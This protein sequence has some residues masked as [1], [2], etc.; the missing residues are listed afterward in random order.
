M[1]APFTS[2]ADDS[3]VAGKEQDTDC[4]S[5]ADPKNWWSTG[6]RLS[7]KRVVVVLVGVTILAA[8][9]FIAHSPS[10]IAEGIRNLLDSICGGGPNAS[11]GQTAGFGPGGGSTAADLH[12]RPPLDRPFRQMGSR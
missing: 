4:C 11:S 3:T 7:P 8:Y 1:G 5:C 9:I 12:R 2:A 10:R 6:K